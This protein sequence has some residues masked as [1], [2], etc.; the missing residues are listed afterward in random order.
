MASFSGFRR[1][2]PST[3]SKAKLKESAPLKPIFFREPSS[4]SS[5]S[6][7]R[8]Q[9]RSSRSAASLRRSSFFSFAGTGA[10]SPSRTM[11]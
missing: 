11:A 6:I 8:S 10:S 5:T 3:T 9:M 4:P 7:K 2:R 1:A